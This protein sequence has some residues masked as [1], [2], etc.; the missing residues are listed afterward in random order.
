MVNHNLLHGSYQVSLNDLKAASSETI[1]RLVR[2]DPCDE[3]P[4]ENIEVPNRYDGGTHYENAPCVLYI[5]SL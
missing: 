2:A 4:T 5:H 3:Y 1:K